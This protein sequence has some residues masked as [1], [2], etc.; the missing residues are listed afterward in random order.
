MIS[1]GISSCITSKKEVDLILYNAKVYTVDSSFSIQEC[2]VIDSGYI[3]ETGQQDVLLKKYN[4]KKSIDLKGKFVYPGFIDAHCHFFGYA[5]DQLEA[6]VADTKSFDEVI[7]TLQNFS[8]NNKNKWIVGRG[9]DQ[10]DWEVKEFP[11]KRKLD[12]VFKD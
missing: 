6:D 12:S 3:L 11:N 2:V 7:E 8:K 1:I 4:T 9:W 10:N 5:I